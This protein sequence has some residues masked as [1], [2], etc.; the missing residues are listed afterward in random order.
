MVGFSDKISAVG[1]NISDF[2]S[3]PAGL[4]KPPTSSSN[5]SEIGTSA[6]YCTTT[7]TSDSYEV[8]VA[9]WTSGRGHVSIAA[10]KE[11]TFGL[12]VCCVKDN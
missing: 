12:S 10:G 9:I 3:L 2:S 7:V 4:R 6:R 8:G 11:K 1:S 5:F